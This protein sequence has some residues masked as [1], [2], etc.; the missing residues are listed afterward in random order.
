MKRYF[1]LFLFCLFASIAA[2]HAAYAAE[3]ANTVQSSSVEDEQKADEYYEKAM[4]HMEQAY[5]QAMDQVQNGRPGT[6]LNGKSTGQWV[7]EVFFG[8]Y[9]AIRRAAPFICMLSL[10]CGVTVCFLAKRN[11]MLFKRAIEV[12]II[13]IP[14]VLLVF[15]FGIGSMISVFG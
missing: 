13:G 3:E 1:I 7:F 10:L 5:Y 9:S 11:K 15:V 2:A 14:L 6:L 12:G 4:D 8:I